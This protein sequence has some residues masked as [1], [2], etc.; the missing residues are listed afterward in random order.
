MKKMDDFHSWFKED[1]CQRYWK[2]PSIGIN[3]IFFK[4][5]V[6]RC[7]DSNP[8]WADAWAEYLLTAATILSENKNG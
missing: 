1:F 7:G 4:S 3:E 6:N 8:K 5:G 2:L